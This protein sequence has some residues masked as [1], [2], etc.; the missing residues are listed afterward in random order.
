MRD[1]SQHEKAGAAVAKLSVLIRFKNE[2]RYI[3]SVLRAV[4]A[5]HCSHEVELVAIDNA[6]TDGSRDIARELADRTLDIHDY[7]PGAALNRAMEACSGDGVIVLSA[8]AIPASDTW[9][10]TVAAWMGNPNVV[11]TYGAQLYPLTARFLDKRDLD[12]FSDSRPRTETHDTDFW[13]ANAAF[14]RSFWEKQPF[15]GLVF[16]LEDHYWTKCLLPANGWW[17]RFEPAALVYHY[18]HELRNDRTFVPP[19]TMS[20]EERIT[21]TTKALAAEGQPWPVVMSAGLTL[22]SLN[23]NP[24]VHSAVPVLGQ[25]LLGHEDFDV[26]WRMAGALGRIASS[27]SAEYLVQ[28]LRDP[29]FYPRDESAWALARLRE[30]AVPV[31]LRSL[32][33]LD[34]ATVPFAALAL[35]MSGVAEAEHRAVDLLRTCLA[36]GDASIVRDALYFLGELPIRAAAELAGC[37][38]RCLRSDRGEVVRAAAWCWGQLARLAPAERLPGDRDVVELARCHPL[39]TIR[40]E[41]VVALGKLARALRSQRLMA[42]VSR[43]LRGDGAGRVRYGAM[44]SLRLAAGEGMRCA[45]EVVAHDADSDFGVRFERDLLL[46]LLDG[47]RADV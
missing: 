46:R 27:R 39:E 29:S 26:R 40:V 16:E 12:I 3:G 32:P 44:Q 10:E 45:A 9:L 5:Q 18:G 36:S 13:N 47:R 4:R 11:G 7:R 34:A 17:V 20:D 15:D 31:V 24:N 1:A 35:G 42:E 2:A 41:G 8:H 38:A 23:R 21:A 14:H 6:S 22:A 43:A 19:S 37:A 30:L 28:G 25:Q 33:E